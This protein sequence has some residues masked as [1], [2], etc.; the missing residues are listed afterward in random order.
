MEGQSLKYVKTPKKFEL[1]L[2]PEARKGAVSLALSN[3]AKEIADLRY[4]N[5]VVLHHASSTEGPLKSVRQ[6]LTLCTKL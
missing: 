4:S 6:E 2:T 3:P 5:S 1:T